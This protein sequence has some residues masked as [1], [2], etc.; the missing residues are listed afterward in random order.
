MSDILATVAI[1]D[2]DAE[3][4][5]GKLKDALTDLHETQVRL[6]Q[7]NASL[8]ASAT[9]VLGVMGSIAST[10]ASAAQG[11]QDLT[12]NTGPAAQSTGGFASALSNLRGALVTS[13]GALQDYQADLQRIQDA[14][15]TVAAAAASNSGSLKDQAEVLKELADAG[16]GG[17]LGLQQNAAALQAMSEQLQRGVPLTDEQTKALFNMVGAVQDANSTVLTGRNALE[18]YNGATARTTGLIRESY[19]ALQNFATTLKAGQS[20][21]TLEASA[22]KEL[23]DRAKDGAGF[24]KEQAE[25]LERLAKA[26]QTG[27][28]LTQEQAQA[29]QRLTSEY[30]EANK[31]ALGLRDATDEN[32]TAFERFKIAALAV[33][34]VMVELGESALDYAEEAAKDAART[35]VLGTVLGVVGKNAKQSNTDLRATVEEVKALGITTQEAEQS[36]IKFIQAQ[37]K[38]SDAAKLARVAQDLAVVAGTNSSEAFGRLTHAIEANSVMMLRQFGIV[39]TLRQVFADYAQQTGKNAKELDEVDKKQAFLNA[40]LQ[41]GAK[42]AGAYEAAMGDVGKQFTS[43]DRLFEEVRDRIGEGLL[44]LFRA[45]VTLLTGLTEGFL[46]LPEPIQRATSAALAFAAAMAVVGGALGAAKLLGVIELLEQVGARLIALPALITGVT[47]TFAGLKTAGAVLGGLEIE[48]EGAGAAATGFSGAL[49]V[50]VEFLGG[51]V[52]ATILAVTAVV[53]GV[54]AAFTL[55]GHTSKDAFNE[56]QGEAAK[57]KASIDPI[58]QLATSVAKLHDEVEKH[59][60]DK[61]PILVSLQADRVQQYETQVSSL[62]DKIGA[63]R[64]EIDSL[65]GST[66]VYSSKLEEL[67]DRARDATHEIGEK[68]TAALQ[69]ANQKYLD[70]V[71]DIGRYETAVRLAEEAHGDVNRAMELTREELAKNA[72]AISGQKSFWSDLWTVLKSGASSFLD[73][74]KKLGPA[75]I[76]WASK[77]GEGLIKIAEIA[78]KIAPPG[79]KFN[80]DDAK[81]QLD[82]LKTTIGGFGDWLHQKAQEDTIA[83]MVTMTPQQQ[84]ERRKQLEKIKAEAKV[85]ADEQARF[86][87]ETLRPVQ[88]TSAD[89]QKALQAA[90]DK[91]FGGLSGPALDKKKREVMSAAGSVWNSL[92]DGQK[93]WQAAAAQEAARMP[94]D[95]TGLPKPEDIAKKLTEITTKVTAATAAAQKEGDKYKKALEQFLGI[96]PESLRKL[97]ALGAA[98]KATEGDQ[99]AYFAV[100]QRGGAELKKFNLLTD[101]QKAKLKDVEALTRATA[102]S[103]DLYRAALQKAA[104]KQVIDVDAA[105]Q[106]GAGSVVAKM[107]DEEIKARDAADKKILDMQRKFGDEQFK[108]EQDIYERLAV[109]QMKAVDQAV[110]AEQKRLAEIVHAAQEEKAARLQTIEDERKAVLERA[111]L[112]DEE[113]EKLRDA[114]VEKQEIA[115]IEKQAALQALLDAKA[116]GKAVSDVEIQQAQVSV[117]VAQNTRDKVA[118]ILDAR[119]HDAKTNIEL[120]KLAGLQQVADD[121]TR[122]DQLNANTDRLVE[123]QSSASALMVKRIRASFDQVRNFGKDLWTN[124]SQAFVTNLQKMIEGAESFKDFMK[125]LWGTIRDTILGFFN[126]LLSGWLQTLGKM[127]AQKLGLNIVA[128]VTGG[129]GMTGSLLNSG[130]SRLLGYL[131]GGAATAG[132]LGTTAAAAGTTGAA[133][134]L[135]GAGTAGLGLGA[136][137][138]GAGVGAAAGT[139]AVAGTAAP[140]TGLFGLTAGTGATLAG[141]AAGGAVGGI[142]GYKVGSST[143]SYAK[144]ALS[145]AA[146]GAATGFAVGGPYGAAIGGIVGLIAGL[147]GAGKARDAA[148]EARKGYIDAAGGLQELQKQ[149]ERAHASLDALMNAKSPKQLQKAIDDLSK[150]FQLQQAKDGLASTYGEMAKLDKQAQL[151]GFD[152]TKVFNAKTI[153][154][155]NAQQDRLNKLLAEQQK[156][157]D[158]LGVAAQGTQQFATGFAQTLTRALTDAIGPDALDNFMKQLDDA[159]KKGFTGTVQD[160][161][162]Q[163]SKNDSADLPNITPE[164]M[165]RLQKEIERSQTDFTALGLSAEHTFAQILHETGDVVQAMNA[166]APTLDAL[167]DAQKNWGFQADASLQ[168]LLGLRQIIKDNEDIFNSIS[169][170]T[171]ILQGLSDAGALTEDTFNALGDSAANQLARLQERGA[172]ANQSLLA[173]QPTLQALW[174][175]QKQFGFQT[176]EATQALI[177]QGIQQGIVGDQFQSINEKMLDILELIAVQLGATLPEAYQNS[178]RAAQQSAQTQ[179][180]ALND[181]RQ[182]ARD[183]GKDVDGLSSNYDAAATAAEQSAARQSAA[184]SGA[185]G[186]V[187]GFSTQVS[188]VQR[189]Y[190]QTAQAAETAASTQA[191]AAG[192]AGA[193]VGGLESQLTVL[194]NQYVQAATAAGISSDQQAQFLASGAGASLTDLQKA[195]A[196]VQAGYAE[197]AKAAAISSS[198]QAAALNAG[199]TT[200]LGTVTTQVEDLKVKYDEAASAAKNSSATQSSVIDTGVTS[201]LKDAISQIDTLKAKYGATAGSASDS[202][203]DQSQAVQQ[204]FSAIDNLLSR[205]AE[206]RKGY[207][208]ATVAADT[209][210]THAESAATGAAEGHSPT[211]LKQVSFRLREGIDLLHEFHRVF[212]ER[213]K[214]IEGMGADMGASISLPTVNEGAVPRRAEAT[215]TTGTVVHVTYEAPVFHNNSLDSADMETAFRKKIL[216]EYYRHLENNTDQLA[217]KTEQHAAKYRKTSR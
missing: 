68:A 105:F 92:L 186:A 67:R 124:I 74:L 16:K 139:A 210:G 174:E 181:A 161:L 2:T 173:M 134:G 137:S 11:V 102:V 146:S 69:Q 116:E 45:W 22:L 188:G 153:E 76:E 99:Q 82:E 46:K 131:G 64:F 145:G 101:D 129:N 197:A 83:S 175:A 130:T 53:G 182:A 217:A 35:E 165:Q 52:V 10:A 25:Q 187:S 58:N 156:R 123:E 168:K 9:G 95:V 91:L 140:T 15:Q 141:G 40:V 59:K 96:D 196:V 79:F 151:V 183:A 172:D 143:G 216:P 8:Q 198:D 117:E 100:I 24:T 202:G 125:S 13:G 49:T 97:D 177:N 85:A 39:T 48:I 32:T 38:A 213:S 160:F 103:L 81:K 14:L 164:Q 43:L 211:G 57:A 142:V 44:P 193:A 50:L 170:I 3:D 194:R 205:L 214:A 195:I 51:P 31:G 167:A 171:Q 90:T 179:R 30:A 41:E 107:A 133:A 138:L 7:Q 111:R 209:F 155:F 207:E 72:D 118:T 86:I 18:T 55:F 115:V 121:K 87:N 33:S 189:A 29:I 122:V 54:V 162:K 135:A 109:P 144:G 128:N 17:V 19:Q 169:G 71:T 37:L 61:D 149:A 206:I 78:N 47:E 136:G 60:N 80:V 56:L 89:Y 26:V 201:S 132:L 28:P 126:Q 185:A 12:A 1:D 204:P 77:I 70:A 114:A 6:A 152:I 65:T 62:K 94:V 191:A 63:F 154:D 203:D 112:A 5:V 178:A 88:T 23:A 27:A 192:A 119:L 127:A 158:A 73:H 176:D 190:D 110:Y 200:S 163:Q 75:F 184:V 66:V 166:I 4:K 42:F 215:G 148:E 150:A 120:Q 93:K 84:E 36:V 159:R 34:A 106:R 113:V 157:L 21:T 208:A 180:D 104:D 147:I 20:A 199:V 98:L 108:Q 212:E